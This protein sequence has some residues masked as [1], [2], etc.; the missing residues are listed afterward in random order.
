LK[1]TIQGAILG[2]QVPQLLGNK[3][4]VWMFRGVEGHPID[5]DRYSGAMEAFLKFLYRK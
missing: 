2:D 4:N 3:G 5:T 1:G